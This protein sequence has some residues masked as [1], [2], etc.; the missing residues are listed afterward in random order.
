MLSMLPLKRPGMLPGKVPLNETKRPVF[1]DRG[2]SGQNVWLESPNGD[3]IQKLVAWGANSVS[4]D[5]EESTVYLVSNSDP[6]PRALWH[7][8]LKGGV[9]MSEGLLEVQ[10][11]VFSIRFCKPAVNK[12]KK[13][14]SPELCAKRSQMRQFL[15]NHCN[16]FMGKF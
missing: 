14:F 4:S 16:K 2:I 7:A 6:Q 10:F 15:Q 11:A 13:I 8:V 5:L 12:K 3:Q 1:F 9:V